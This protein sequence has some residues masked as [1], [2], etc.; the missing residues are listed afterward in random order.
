MSHN[1]EHPSDMLLC[2]YAGGG[3]MSCDKAL[4]IG[5]H[6]KSCRECHN[7]YMAYYDEHLKNVI[8]EK[9]FQREDHIA[10][11]MSD[12][13]KKVACLEEYLSNSINNMM[14]H[15]TKE[16]DIQSTLQTVFG[17]NYSA[18]DSTHPSSGNPDAQQATMQEFELLMLIRECLDTLTDKNIDII[19]RT[20]LASQLYNE[21]LRNRNDVE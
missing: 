12:M 7:K 2:S 11:R 5:K 20:D 4:Y 9:D 15:F 19:R 1:P 21:I 6:I 3:Y 8:D 14:P 17:L 18:G 10:Q 16:K 13:W